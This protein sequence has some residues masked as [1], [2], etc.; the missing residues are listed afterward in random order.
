MRSYPVMESPIGA[1]VSEILRY[2]QTD[3]QTNKQTS[4]YFNIRIKD[5]ITFLGL[6]YRDASIIM[7][8]QKSHEQ[9]N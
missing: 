9:K 2:T 3:T 5:I 4:C 8:F 7:V 6:D 1:A